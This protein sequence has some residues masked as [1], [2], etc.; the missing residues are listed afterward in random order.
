MGEV[1]KA[2][3]AKLRRDVAIK[4]LPPAFAA[5]PDLL[6]RLEREAMSLAAVSHP[7]V[8]AIHGL[9]EHAGVRY[10]VLE[11]VDGDTLAAR[12]AAGPISVR[13][14]LEIALQIADALEAAH[15]RGVIHRDLKPG[16]VMLTPE[17]RVKVLDFGL[18]KSFTSVGG[19]APTAYAAQTEIGVIMGTAPYM[20]PEQARG[21]TVGAQT[22][23]W[24]FGVMLYEM[25]TGTSPFARA[26]TAETLARVLEADPDVGRL[27]D[28]T[29][30]S[31]RHLVSRCLEKERRRRVK[32]AGDVR[33][34]VE[35]GL[36]ELAAGVPPPLTRAGMSRRAALTAAGAALG[37]VGAG[38]GAAALRSRGVQPAAAPT[39]Q[40]LTFRRGMIRT[41][42]FAPDFQTILY[43]ALWDGDVCRVYTVRT[44]SPESAAPSLPPAAPLAVS[45]LGELALALGAHFRGIMTYG[46]LARVPL[47]GGAPREVEENIK[48][49]DWSPDGRDLA[50]VRGMG[51][52]DQL[53][54]PAGTMLAKPETPAGGSVSRGS[55]PVATP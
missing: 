26:T 39:Y 20:S 5:N 18:A 40:R 10:L 14:A 11:L 43:G 1:W 15:E 30:A 48:Y 37:L 55:R 33:I 42:R 27:P 3:D 28:A 22:D 53:E 54:F 32:H 38:F 4:T 8:A 45:V 19:A 46:T 31:V 2:R 49:A 17:G 44:D 36:A 13:P 7:N 29:P 23:I 9:E 47:A 24:S 25:L 16:N 6:A 12:L 21:E 35:E 51:D 50:I 41:A 34:G 52:H